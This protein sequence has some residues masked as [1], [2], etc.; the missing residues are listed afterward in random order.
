M[1]IYVLLYRQTHYVL[2]QGLEGGAL[3]FIKL[4]LVQGIHQG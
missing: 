1:L 3:I 2:F 4:A